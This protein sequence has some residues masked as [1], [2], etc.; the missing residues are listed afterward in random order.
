MTEGLR[1]FDQPADEVAIVDDAHARAMTLEVAAAHGQH[2]RG[3][4]I[5]DEAIVVDVHLEAAA[6][7]TRGHG[8]KDGCT[9][10][11]PSGSP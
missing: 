8:V 1:L 5:T 3:A 9:R 6:D 7:Q 2:R 4:E 11:W 10:S